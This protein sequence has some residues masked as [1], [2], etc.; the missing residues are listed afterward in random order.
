M[1][2]RS[3]RPELMDDPSCDTDR[4]L[5]TVAQFETINRL[6]SRFRSILA[7][8]VLDDMAM[9]PERVY[10]L[11]DI[12]AGG[13]DIARWLLR[14]AAERGLK[15]TVTALDS[16]A[17]ICEWARQRNRGVRGLVIEQ[18][19]A[20]SRLPEL[21]CDYIFGNHFLH[22][23]DDPAIVVM[24]NLAVSIARR[25]VVFSD[26]RRSLWALAGFS[27]LAAC[28]FRG[29]FALHDGCLSIRRGFLKSELEAMARH[30]DAERPGRVTSTWPGRLVLSLEGG[31]SG[32]R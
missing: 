8:E 6:L 2:R 17:R 15:L 19:D 22:H 24:L 13:G 18:G 26:L 10:H 4:L 28:C 32:R 9:A 31:R 25:R 20:F 16:D 3:L 7:R 5:R 1:S 14:A 23:L 30:V 11:V 29:S 27:L 12:G 21:R